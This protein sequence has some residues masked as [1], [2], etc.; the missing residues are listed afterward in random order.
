MN[1]ICFVGTYSPIMCGIADYTEFITSQIPDREWGVLSFDLHRFNG[2]LVERNGQ[3]RQHIHYG[4]PDFEHFSATD[5]LQGLQQINMD[6]G[7]TVLWFQHENGIWRNDQGFVSMMRDLKI[8]KIVTLH[9]LHFQNPETK[10]GLTENEYA[11]LKDLLPRVNAITVFSKGVYHAVTKAFP[12][13]SRKVYVI[14]HGLPLSPEA[15]RLSRQEAR[16]KL[17]DY[18]IHKSHL[19]EAT[20]ESLLHHRI[21]ANT[22]NFIIGETGFLCS[23]KQSELLFTIRDTLSKMIPERQIIALRIGVARDKCQTEYATSLRQYQNDKDKF[24]I[25]TCLPEDMLRVAQRAFDVN[26]YWPEQCTQSGILAHALGAGSIV[27][28]RDMEG[29]GE[30]LKDA[31][32]ICEKDMDSLISEMKN[33]LVNP[34]ISFRMEQE[35]LRYASE[36]SWSAQ[37]QAHR[38]LAQTVMLSTF[39]RLVPIYGDRIFRTNIPL[40][41]SASV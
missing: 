31:G 34:D 32:A 39:E 24:L 17:N 27:A 23:G 9:T 40:W 18:L 14:K 1:S 15:S 5:I 33:L 36:F 22:D 21:L 19:P 25:E 11:F 3:N 8:P 28:G 2:N 29:S 10:Y 26:F 16:I 20:K 37:A 4:I 35:A 30:M 12:E 13:S 7:S 6:R 41:N 38:K